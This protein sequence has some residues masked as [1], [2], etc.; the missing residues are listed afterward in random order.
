MAS[1]KNKR[2]ISSP[3]TMC[4]TKH[5]FPG[6]LASLH[7]FNHNLMARKKK[8]GL[9]KGE[10]QGMMQQQMTQFPSAFRN[11]SHLLWQTTQTFD[12]HFAFA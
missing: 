10:K 1:T 6:L 3:C 12:L 4:S 2:E 7:S 8:Q 5:C 9:R 11:T